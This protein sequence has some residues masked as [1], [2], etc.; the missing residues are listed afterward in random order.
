MVPAGALKQVAQYLRDTQG[1]PRWTFIT[2]I[3]VVGGDLS[4]TFSFTRGEA[5]PSALLPGLAP[6]VKMYKGKRIESMQ[7]EGGSSEATDQR[8]AAGHA[9][10]DI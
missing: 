2:K 7:G 10:M 5:V 3:A 8:V 1:T 9:E 6:V 4:N